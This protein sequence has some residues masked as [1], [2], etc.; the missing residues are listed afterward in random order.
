MLGR[1]AELERYGIAPSNDSRECHNMGPNTT[2]NINGYGG[3]RGGGGVMG[4]VKK[5]KKLCF[6]GARRIF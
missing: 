1:L 3:V 5:G 2:I 6:F 4:G